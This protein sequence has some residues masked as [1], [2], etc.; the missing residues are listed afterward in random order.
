MLEF[1]ESSYLALLY[2]VSVPAWYWNYVNNT[3]T[4]QKK[5]KEEKMAKAQAHPPPSLLLSSSSICTN[6]PR[7]PTFCL[8]DQG[9]TSWMW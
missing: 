7:P 3:F 9:G 5:K 4:Y 6:P 1:L 2:F 8:F